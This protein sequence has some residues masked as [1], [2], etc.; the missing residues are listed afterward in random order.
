[1][2]NYQ[3]LTGK[4]HLPYW[5]EELW[6]EGLVKFVGQAKKNDQLLCAFYEAEYSPF[7]DL[8]KKARDK[9]VGCENCI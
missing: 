5:A 6:T 7:F 1:L 8:L 4:K 9:G 2:K 3:E